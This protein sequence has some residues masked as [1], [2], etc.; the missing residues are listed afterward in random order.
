[1]G[2]C[3]RLYSAP[4]SDLYAFAGAPRT[5]QVWLRYPRPVPEVSLHGHW[6]DLD[7]ILGSEPSAVSNSPLTPNSADWKYPTAADRGAYAL[8]STSTEVLLHLIERIGRPQVETYVRQRWVAEALQTGQPADPTPAQLASR[9]E[10]LLQP[11]A[12][13]RDSCRLAQSKGYGL[14]MALWEED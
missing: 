5:L 10:E 11:L 14:L 13:L 7:A 12:L 3:M 8:T 2:I 1:M 9:T 6:L 4:D